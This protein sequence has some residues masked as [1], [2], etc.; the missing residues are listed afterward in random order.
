MEPGVTFEANRNRYRV[1]LHIG[2]YCIY[3]SEF[4]SEN[5]ANTACIR[6]KNDINYARRYGKSNRMELGV[7]FEKKRKRYRVRL[8]VGQDCVHRSAYKSRG[9]ANAQCV[10]ERMKLKNY[11]SK[12][13]LNSSNPIDGVEFFRHLH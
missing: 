3:R 13:T 4:K 5:E 1:R 11:K 12:P 6:V 10:L 9:K 8:Y 2:R 7:S